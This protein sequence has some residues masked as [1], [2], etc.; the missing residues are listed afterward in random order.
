MKLSNWHVQSLKLKAMNKTKA[1]TKTAMYWR[2]HTESM[3][4]EC[5]VNDQT[6]IMARPFEIFGKI[7]YS[8]ADRAREL[9]DPELNSLMCRLT[10][11]TQA[12]PYS[13]DY[14]KG[15]QKLI[16]DFDAKLIE[17][18]RHE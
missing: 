3:L 5:L 14:D 11:F 13:P 6:K 4:K 8:V 2:V 16:S 10:L 17:R 9:N 15:V 18:I 7:L 1:I 12:D